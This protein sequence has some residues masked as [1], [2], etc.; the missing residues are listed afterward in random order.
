LRGAYF[1]EVAFSACIC[2]LAILF[3]GSVVKGK[4]FMTLAGEKDQDSFSFGRVYY[5]GVAPNKALKPTAREP[6]IFSVCR[7]AGLSL[8]RWV[9]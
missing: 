1:S 7:F 9:S 8:G 2:R 6:A 4:S 3:I 5:A